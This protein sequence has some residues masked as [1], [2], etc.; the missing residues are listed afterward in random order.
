[1]AAS[2][3]RKRKMGMNIPIENLQKRIPLPKE[4]IQ[5]A[6]KTILKHEGIRKAFLSFAFVT[7]QKIKSIHKKYLKEN[8]ATDVLTFDLGGQVPFCARSRKSKTALC[9]EI[10][11]SVDTAFKNAKHYRTSAEYEI[12]LYVVHGILHLLGFNDH[13]YLD[14]KQMRR[15]EKEL[16]TFLKYDYQD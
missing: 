13:S 16:M 5:K 10:I 9:G 2:S 11:I 12:M 6:V 15:K 14:I 7:D 3:I 1:M 8:H 4:Q